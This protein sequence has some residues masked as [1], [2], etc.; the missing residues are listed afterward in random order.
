MN[1]P[2]QEKDF[3]RYTGNRVPR[4]IRLVWT[5]LLIFAVY[6]LVM[7][8]VPDLSHWLTRLK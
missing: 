8:F 1:E 6:Y 3:L 5:A 4:I 7:F 2:T